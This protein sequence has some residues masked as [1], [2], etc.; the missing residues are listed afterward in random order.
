MSRITYGY[1]ARRWH[2]VIFRCTNDGIREPIWLTIPE[3]RAW[4]KEDGRLRRFL[5]RG[6]IVNAVW[7]QKGNP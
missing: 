5:S 3:M 7:P 1:N 2:H 4:A 6:G